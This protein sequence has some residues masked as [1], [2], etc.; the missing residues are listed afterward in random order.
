MENKTYVEFVWDDDCG[1]DLVEIDANLT[2][3]EL[4][5]IKKAKDKFLDE[6]FADENYDNEKYEYSCLVETVMNSFP[7][8][9][10]KIN[11]AMKIYADSV[12]DDLKE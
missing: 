10:R 5:A 9:W 12:Y 4:V 6:K 2:D 1:N 3:E 8:T 11:L 7:W